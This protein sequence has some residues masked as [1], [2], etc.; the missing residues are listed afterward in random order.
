MNWRQVLSFEDETIDFSSVVSQE[1]KKALDA[2]MIEHFDKI[3]G[4]LISAV[5]EAYG[6][7]FHYPRPGRIRVVA[8]LKR[9]LNDIAEDY[10]LSADWDSTGN[11][12]GILNQ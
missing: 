2:A 6:P 3:A 12:G 7:D 1:Q 5:E 4:I 10:V 11:V 8:M 9:H